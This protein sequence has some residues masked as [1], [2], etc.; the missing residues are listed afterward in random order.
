[1]KQQ[2]AALKQYRDEADRFRKESDQLKSALAELNNRIRPAAEAT[3]EK[4]STIDKILNR[5]AWG[6]AAGKHSSNLY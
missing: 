6:Q 2:Q 3:E 5:R 4:E 1:M